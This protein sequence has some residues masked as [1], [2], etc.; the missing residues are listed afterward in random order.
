MS[1]TIAFNT[2]TNNAADVTAQRLA[3]LE[4]RLLK[5]AQIRGEFPTSLNLLSSIQTALDSD[6]AGIQEIAGMVCVD[7]VLALRVISIANYAYYR[8]D[9]AV[10]S[11]TEALHCIGLT[12]LKEILPSL[13]EEKNFNAIYLGR[14]VSV[15]MMQQATLA[16]LIARGAARLLCPQHNLE[17]EAYITSVL[18]NLGPLL[19]AFY[20]PDIYSALCLDCMDDRGLFERVFRRVMR[21]SIVEFAAAMVQSLA[22]PREFETFLTMLDEPPWK[23]VSQSRRS[24]NEQFAVAASV[25]L[26]NLLAHEICYFTGIQGIQSLMRELDTAALIEQADLEDLI[27][28]VPDTYMEHSKTLAL[29]P[30]RLPEYLLWFAP[31]NIDSKP[32]RWR[33][34]LPG[35]NERINPYLYELRA[36]FKTKQAGREL[37]LLPHAV[38]CTLSAL[39]K[40]LSFDRA[41]LFRMD[42]DTRTLQPVICHGVKL[43]QPEKLRRAVDDPRLQTQPDVAACRGKKT[44]LTGEPIFDDGWPFLCFPVICGNRVA[45]VFYADKIRKPDSQPLD[46]QEQISGIALS[47]EWRDIPPDFR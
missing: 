17:E 34:A 44:I 24:G 28:T 39:I 46:S 33:L 16:S 9:K 22:L 4:G 29:K 10:L 37:C 38:Y 18:S 8:K 42:E 40:G 7:H 12:K 26:A 3:G 31:V 13:A 14:A 5:S 41:L 43:Y 19:L 32:V 6:H 45:A 23:K 30:V 1:L 27:G 35:I 15:T 25:Y 47:E 20:R 11:V 36:C 21:K 2:L